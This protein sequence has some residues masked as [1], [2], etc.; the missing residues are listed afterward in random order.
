M[1]TAW[2]IVKKRYAGNAFDGEGARL[3]GGRWSSPGVRVV[4]LASSRSL[5]LLEIAVHLERTALASSYVLVGCA[6]DDR[7][8]AHVPHDTLPAGW[9]RAPPPASLAA[10]GDAWIRSA[11]SAVLAVPSAVIPQETN[12]LLNPG[13]PDFPE[14]AIGEPEDIELDA[15]LVR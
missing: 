5:A 9:R 7:M 12:Y 2:R 3:F 13:H 6:F 15:R 14:V 4:Y 8:I 11:R 1:P 10:I